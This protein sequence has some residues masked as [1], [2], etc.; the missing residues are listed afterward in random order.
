V[1]GWLDEG[2]TSTAA[3]LSGFG[4]IGGS[5]MSAT[6]ISFINLSTLCRFF[7]I[8]STAT[9]GS[10]KSS[11]AGADL[12]QSDGPHDLLRFFCF[13]LFAAASGLGLG[14]GD[15]FRLSLPPVSDVRLFSFLV[16]SASLSLESL[17]LLLVGLK[18]FSF[19][20]NICSK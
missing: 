18:P 19:A 20:T 3:F 2:L 15:F 13:S 16:F 1:T 11:A 4:G 5:G 10:G 14:S 7:E 9:M 8:T 6:L 17:A 12:C